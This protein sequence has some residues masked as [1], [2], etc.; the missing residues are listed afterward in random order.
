MIL[1]LFARMLL[2]VTLHLN[3]CIDNSND[4]QKE[5]PVRVTNWGTHVMSV[6]E[7][8][9][10]DK[11][12]LIIKQIGKIEYDKMVKN[13][14]IKNIPKEMTIFSKGSPMKDRSVLHKKLD[15]LKVY[16][17]ATFSNTYH[18]RNYGNY[19]ILRCPY[20]KNILWD[21]AVKWDTIY[22]IVDA[23]VVEVIK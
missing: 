21:S 8:Y 2:V 1:S 16:Q 5:L 19:A 17:I 20:D 10:N 12:S 9:W 11:D 18:G 4:V 6:A 22:F 13:S 3:I 14:D 7:D 15:Q 23:K